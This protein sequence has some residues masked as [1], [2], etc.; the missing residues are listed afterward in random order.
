MT[1]VEESG[2]VWR[3]RNVYE[4]CLRCQMKYGYYLDIKRA[5]ER[6]PGREDLKEW[7]K[8]EGRK[9]IPG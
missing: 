4:R 8:C 9:E 3:N 2:H 7:M 6:Q 1:Q 5:S